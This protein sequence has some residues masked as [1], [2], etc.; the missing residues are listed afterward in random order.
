MSLCLI[1]KGRISNPESMMTQGIICKRGLFQVFLFVKA[2]W[3]F[4]KEK[5]TRVFNV[6]KIERSYDRS[7]V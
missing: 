4:T 2:K 6:D 1:T 7:K 3:V 5:I